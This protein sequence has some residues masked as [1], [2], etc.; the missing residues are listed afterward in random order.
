MNGF[1]RLA[2]PA[3]AW[4]PVSPREDILRGV[5]AAPRS[6]GDRALE[7]AEPLIGGGVRAPGADAREARSRAGRVMPG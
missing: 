5:R 6:D 4:S 3:G 1:A 2:A 7:L